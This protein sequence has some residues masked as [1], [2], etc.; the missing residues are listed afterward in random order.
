MP[1]GLVAVVVIVVVGFLISMCGAMMD[2][3]RAAPYR[4]LG[5]SVGVET[6]IPQ[7][8]ATTYQ[9]A[10][11]AVDGQRTKKDV[12]YMVIDGRLVDS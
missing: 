8:S 10:A 9:N 4:K 5:N 12:T 2:K 6:A 1:P 11:S 7:H 3:T